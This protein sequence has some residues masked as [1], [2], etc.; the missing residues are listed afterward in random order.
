MSEALQEAVGFDKALACADDFLKRKKKQKEDESGVCHGGM[1][2]LRNG[3]VHLH[4]L[5]ECEVGARSLFFWLASAN[6]DKKEGHSPFAHLSTYADVLDGKKR[7]LFVLGRDGVLCIQL[8]AGAKAHIANGFPLKERLPS[9]FPN[10]RDCN[11]D[12]HG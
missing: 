1:V 10:C 6:A 3:V 8:R 2:F 11:F 7:E 4:V 9:R 5:G 12:S